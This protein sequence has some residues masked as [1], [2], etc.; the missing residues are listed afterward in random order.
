[1]FTMT[2]RG[3]DE[4]T[5]EALKERA[6]K[7]RTS[8]KVRTC[9]IV[10]VSRKKSAREGPEEIRPPA[11]HAPGRAAVFFA[12]FLF[13]GIKSKEGGERCAAPAVLTLSEDEKT[14]K[15]GGRAPRRRHTLLPGLK[16]MQ[17]R[18]R[19]WRGARLRPPDRF[20][21]N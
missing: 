15:P 16:S 9:S 5:A 3:I 12:S 13:G 19:H 6:Q 4:K 20:P 2:L 1:M 8:V 14:T 11:F 18:A 10:P 7:E 17:K 21:R